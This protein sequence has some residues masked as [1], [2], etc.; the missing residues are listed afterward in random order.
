VEIVEFR[1]GI[2]YSTIAVKLP[3]EALNDWN[4]THYN[5]GFAWRS[6]SVSF[7]TLSDE[8]ECKVLVKA[9]DTFD[10]NDNACRMIR[11]PFEVGSSGV[12]IASIADRKR[13]ELQEGTYQLIFSAIPGDG[14]TLDAYEFVFIKS[15]APQAE[16]MKADDQ[17]S[18][19]LELLMEAQ[20]AV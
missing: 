19:P 17:L 4:E 2:L 12:E 16:I 3:N 8:P 5:Q 20:P 14:G 18:P 13:I 9:A 1:L 15:D 6:T 11:L 7:G 10:Q